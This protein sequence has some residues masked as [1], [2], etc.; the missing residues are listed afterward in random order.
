MM[1]QTEFAP[2]ATFVAKFCTGRKF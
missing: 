1:K 2:L